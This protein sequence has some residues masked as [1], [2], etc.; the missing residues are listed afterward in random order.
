MSDKQPPSVAAVA[1]A[2]G[3][4]GILVGYFI[5]QGSSIG[6]WNSPTGS[7]VKSKR[8]PP[9]KSWPNS[10][11]VDVHIGDSSDEEFIA[12]IADNEADA[13]S[14]EEDSDQDIKSFTNINEEVKMVLVVRTDLGMTKGKIAAQCGHATLAC[15]KSMLNSKD[16]TALLRR[17]ET[18]GQTKVAVQCKSEEELETLQALAVS[19]G[20]CA[21]IIHD[22]GRTQIAAGSATVMGVVGPKSVVDRVTGSLK[23]L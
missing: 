19:L 23:L 6:V 5:G 10:Y 20:I 17:W 4:L 11:D 2:S 21:K 12:S 9:K 14:E 7:K 13:N 8:A 1:F 3:L 18:M 15:Y 22:A 16:G